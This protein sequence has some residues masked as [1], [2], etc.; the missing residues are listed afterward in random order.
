MFSP[1]SII[2]HES[3][4]PLCG[5]YYGTNDFQSLAVH[6]A[7]SIGILFNC[8]CIPHFAINLVPKANFRVCRPSN[9]FIFFHTYI[10]SVAAL[11]IK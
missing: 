4:S 11:L 1:L 2:A 5:A 8:Y 9:L 3:A 7:T 6:Y 10:S